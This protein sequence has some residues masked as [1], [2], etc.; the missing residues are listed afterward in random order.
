ME[1][2]IDR[3]ISAA[4]AVLW[5]LC[6]SELVKTV[7]SYKEKLGLRSYPHLWSQTL[8]GG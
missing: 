2:E 8:G 1:P 3:R 4:S 5:M 6:Q 7:L